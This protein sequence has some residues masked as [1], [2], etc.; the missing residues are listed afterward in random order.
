MKL[1]HNT[2]P[3]YSFKKTV[4]INKENKEMKKQTQNKKN[5]PKL[6]LCFCFLIQSCALSFFLLRTYLQVMIDKTKYT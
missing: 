6:P 2:E 5:S 3:K 1:F 4:A